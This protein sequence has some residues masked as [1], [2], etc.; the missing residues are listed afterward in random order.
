MDNEAIKQLTNDI[1]RVVDAQTKPLHAK[2][3]NLKEQLES[4][5][6][7]LNGI[8]A[9]NERYRKRDLNAS[10]VLSYENGVDDPFARETL[11]YVDVSVSDNIY[12]VESE[13]VTNLQAE[14]KL[15]RETLK[16][17]VLATPGCCWRKCWN[18]GKSQIHRDSVT[19]GVL[20]RF[21]GSQDT[22]LLEKETQALK[23]E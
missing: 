2:I 19:P 20:C 18:C 21:C 5:W 1:N 7:E 11:K 10:I 6:K 16:E 13:T 17:L 4:A 14:N 12:V 3:E 9:Q 15:S 22:R 23:G 8:K